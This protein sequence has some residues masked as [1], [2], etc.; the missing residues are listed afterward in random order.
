MR[1]FN[2][3]TRRWTRYDNLLTKANYFHSDGVTLRGKTAYPVPVGYIR[4]VTLP[5]Q[6]TIECFSYMVQRVTSDTK[7]DKMLKFRIMDLVQNKICGL[8]ENSTKCIK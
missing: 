2:N 7:Q 5:A 3:L 8:A 4:K 6:I 1:N